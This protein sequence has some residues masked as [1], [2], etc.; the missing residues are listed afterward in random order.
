M[1]CWSLKQRDSFC[2]FHLEGG[3][4]LLYGCLRAMN[5]YRTGSTLSG[6]YS[7]PSHEDSHFFLIFS[8][9]MCVGLSCNAESTSPWL[10]TRMVRITFSGCRTRSV[11]FRPYLGKEL[12]RIAPSD[13][14][15][16]FFRHLLSCVK[17]SKQ[18]NRELSRAFSSVG[19][20]LYL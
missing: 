3:I 2:E 6:F 8:T 7:H 16:P 19:N 11:E 4:G 5:S 1:I 12:F 20:F 17:F 9:A 13:A 14:P 18:K 10:P 15:A